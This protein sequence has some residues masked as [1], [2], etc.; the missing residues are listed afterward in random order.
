MRQI[1]HH[2]GA[3]DAGAIGDRG[4]EGPPAQAVDQPL[5]RFGVEDRQDADRIAGDALG[6]D[7]VGHDQRAQLGRLMRAGLVF[8]VLGLA[9]EIGLL[10][11]GPRQAGLVQVV[12][13]AQVRILYPHRLFQPSAG[14]KGLD[15]H[16]HQPGAAQR[17]PDRQPVAVA[18]VQLEPLFA[19]IGDA[20]G[21]DILAG[22]ADGPEGGEGQGLAV[23]IGGIFHQLLQAG[24]GI[25]APRRRLSPSRPT[26]R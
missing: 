8:Q 22:D 25:R 6:V 7:V 23:Q 12:F 17:V 5:A 2:D 16:S 19:D 10:D 15:P 24:A 20:K 21:D 9:A 1:G 14:G 4:G 3:P 13:G 18:H 11:L 26:G